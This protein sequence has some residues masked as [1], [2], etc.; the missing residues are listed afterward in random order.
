MQ[1]VTTAAEIG[2]AMQA[3][4]EWEAEDLLAEWLGV[5]EAIRD[6]RAGRVEARTA[7]RFKPETGACND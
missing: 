5:L 7:L 2:C 1:A 4:L 6:G 3:T